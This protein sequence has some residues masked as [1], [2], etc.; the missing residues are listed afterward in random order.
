MTEHAPGE[1]LQLLISKTGIELSDPENPL[2]AWVK[3][4]TNGEELLHIRSGKEDTV[5]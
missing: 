3:T 1:E 2:G 5:L 4:D